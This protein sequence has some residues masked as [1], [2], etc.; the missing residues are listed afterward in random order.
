MKFLLA[1]ILT[2]GITNEP[3]TDASIV[4]GPPVQTGKWEFTPEVIVCPHAP[5][6]K[7]RVEEAVNFWKKL[8]YTIGDVVAADEKDFSCSRNIVLH[9]DI[10]INLPG[11]DFRMSKHLATTRTWV[12]KDSRAILKAKIE[13]MGGWGEAERLMEH[14]IGHA[15]GWRDYNQTGHIM[16]SNWSMGGYNTK[17]VKNETT[18]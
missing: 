14:E 13:V 9:G 11:Q 4:F 8:G 12:D 3:T 15:L 18:I 1:L 5:V 10:L 2:H 7:E 17:G 16:H 6:S